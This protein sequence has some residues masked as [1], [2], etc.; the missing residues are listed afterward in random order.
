M[1]RVSLF[2][3]VLV[4]AALLLAACGGQETSTSVPSTNVPPVTMEVT[5]TSEATSTEA[6]T[7]AP[8]LSS[9]MTS[10][11]SVPVTGGNNP[12]QVSNLIGAP[13]CGMDG[14]QAGTV[15]DLVVDFDQSMVTYIVVDANGNTVAVPWTSFDMT[16]AMG[17][18]TGTGTGTGLETSTPSTGTGL[19][20]S[21]P[22]SSTGT[23]L[24]TSTPESS[25]GSGTGTGT[26]SQNCLALT[27]DAATLS[28]APA[29]D[30]S[31]LPAQGQPAMGWDA[32]LSSYWANPSSGGTGTGTGVG[33]E[34]PSAGGTSATAVPSTTS[35]ADT[36]L[37]TAT[38]TTSSSGSGTG[39]GNGLGNNA[40]QMQGVML[41]SDIL[42]ATVTVSPQGN[43]QGAGS[44]SGTGT[45]L[46]TST[47]EAGATAAT[48]TSDTSAGS[49]TGSGASDFSSGTVEDMIVEPQT[50]DVQY[51]VVSFGTSTDWI[52]LPIGFLRWDSS[53]NG[54][55]LMV[56]Q[57]A[58]QNAPTFAPDQF[59]DT[60]MSG[61]DQEW[62]T[63]WQSNGGTGA[64]GGTGSGGISISTATATP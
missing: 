3:T 64:S 29:F 59:P 21:T 8:T 36:G 27:V 22:S 33:T 50:G 51:L 13:V 48:A 35:S 55:V 54:F 32:D 10:T 41:A 9:D 53:T 25:T 58:L 17:S 57:N 30:A 20:T 39:T 37:A 44:G 26:G 43:D 47:P 52:P 12:S 18:G 19:E 14:S 60:S 28:G 56:N 2:S 5:N 11:P 42:G 4:L 6:P 62:S 7:E 46:E 23:G 38:M 63:Y 49:G 16:S 61:W 40:Q 31:T 45:G 15:Q 1:R 24:E 34:T